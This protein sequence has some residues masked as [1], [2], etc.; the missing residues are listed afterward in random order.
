M[1]VQVW[2]SSGVHL[3]AFKFESAGF[4]AHPTWGPDG[5]GLFACHSSSSVS[6][7]GGSGNF[8]IMNTSLSRDIVFGWGCGDLRLDAVQP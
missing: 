1:Q 5:G 4:R 7:F 8:G 2:R 6:I 3:H